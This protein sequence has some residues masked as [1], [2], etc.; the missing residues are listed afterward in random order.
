MPNYDSVTPSEYKLKFKQ[1]LHEVF[2][3]GKDFMFVFNQTHEFHNLPNQ[4]L[5]YL[6]L[7]SLREKDKEHQVSKVRLI[8]Q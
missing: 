1:I 5:I 2:S 4:M 6:L 3:K 8:S 7:L